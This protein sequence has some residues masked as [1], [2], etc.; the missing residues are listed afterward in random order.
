[1]TRKARTPM[2]TENIEPSIAN[3]AH[4]RVTFH[5]VILSVLLVKTSL[6]RWFNVFGA[7]KEKL[8]QRGVVYCRKI[9]WHVDEKSIL[10]NFPLCN[11]VCTFGKN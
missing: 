6:K 11:F 3:R 7:N 2:T 10:A 8:R 5:F 9:E 1:M 4:L